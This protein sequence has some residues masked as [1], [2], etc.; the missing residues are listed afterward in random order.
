VTVARRY[1]VALWAYPARYRTGRGREL[2]STLADGDDD[3]GRPSTREALALAYRGLLERGRIAASGDGLLMIAATLVLFAMFAGLTWAER[4]WV[5]G[6]GVAAIGGDGPGQW[7]GVALTI[8][9]F[10]ILAARPFRA[11]DSPRRRRVAATIAFFAALLIWSAPGA[12]FKY[13]I[14]DAGAAVEFLRW[15]VTGIYHNWNLT[16]P[17]AATASAGTWLALKALSR[18]SEPARRRALA[19]GLFAAGAVAVTLTWARPDTP[20][21]YGRSAFADLGA[22]VFVTA[23]GMLLAVAA[24]LRARRSYPRPAPPQG[25][26]GP[27]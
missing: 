17:F 11:V 6:G 12:L 5:M 25:A 1:R 26:P 23:T 19:A 22:A 20:A 10:A 27:R 18:L 13:S 14:P 3:R 21:P 9:A 8:C 15:N 2:L 4:V 16:L 24:S 7:A